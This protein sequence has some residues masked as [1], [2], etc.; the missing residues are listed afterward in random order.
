MVI[1]L[2]LYNSVI[3]RHY[4]IDWLILKVTFEKMLS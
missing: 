2:L 3:C 1:K 4:V